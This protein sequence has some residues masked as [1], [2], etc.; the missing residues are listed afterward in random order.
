M[1]KV[2]MY[3]PATI[4]DVFSHEPGDTIFTEMLSFTILQNMKRMQDEG[5]KFDDGQATPEELVELAPLWSS[6]DGVISQQSAYI[7]KVKDTFNGKNA[8]MPEEPS[9]VE[10]LLW[11]FGEWTANQIAT[12][13][14][15]QTAGR[16]A[17]F[18]VSL[19][20]YAVSEL[21]KLYTEGGTLCDKI[22]AENT[23]LEA[24]S[25]SRENF[26]LRS[27]VLSRH[28]STIGNLLQHISNMEKVASTASGLSTG[29]G[30]TKTLDDL[31]E[32]VEL[33]ADSENVVQ[34]PYSGDYIYTKTFCRDGV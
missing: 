25:M 19:L 8:S 29:E 16:V 15:G 33:I 22:E 1:A 10:S 27:T 34:C 28:E 31:V 2:D 9:L 32:A 13:F 17:E 7:G 24:L 6:Q 11:E 21:K 30:Q 26:L 23:S 5:F 3:L 14:W 4:P 18:A 12:Y 20:G